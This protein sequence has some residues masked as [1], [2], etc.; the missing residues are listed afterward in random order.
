MQELPSDSTCVLLWRFGTNTISN[1]LIIS[2]LHSQCERSSWHGLDVED[3]LQQLKASQAWT[4]LPPSR[5]PPSNVWLIA[6]SHNMRQCNCQL[7]TS[8]WTQPLSIPYPSEPNSA[9]KEVQVVEKL[10]QF[11]VL[12]LNPK[13]ESS[14][15]RMQVLQ[16]IKSQNHI[17]LL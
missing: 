10:A 4:F 6:I 14:K 17:L 9:D 12:D 15:N 16:N 7:C 1:F 5:A 2:P 13:N 3:L 11:P 8:I